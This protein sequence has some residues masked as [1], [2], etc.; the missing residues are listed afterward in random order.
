[1]ETDWEGCLSVPGLRGQVERFQQIE[2]T[3]FTLQG[4][5]IVEAANKFKARII[6]HE[7]DHLDGI[8]FPYK[9]ADKKAFGFEEVLPLL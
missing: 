2:Y 6:Q 5:K 1:M 8:L 9:L 4:E 3:G 7:I